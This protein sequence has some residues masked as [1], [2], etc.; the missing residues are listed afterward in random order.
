MNRGK[1]ELDEVNAK[2]GIFSEAMKARIIIKLRRV[3]YKIET[4]YEYKSIVFKQQ[5]A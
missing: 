3:K 4:N 1:A 2:N 5:N